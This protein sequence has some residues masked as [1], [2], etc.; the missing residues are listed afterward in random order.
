MRMRT[1]KRKRRTKRMMKRKR[2]AGA[3]QMLKVGGCG[4]VRRCES[5][6]KVSSVIPPGLW[7]DHLVV[8][9]VVEHRQL[10]G[11]MAVSQL[12]FLESYR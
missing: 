5:G 6:D 1:K 11:Q 7:T 10:A 8:V 9:R 4:W 2:A 3:D 12:L